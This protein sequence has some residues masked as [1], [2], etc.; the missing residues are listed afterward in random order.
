MLSKPYFERIPDQSLI[1]D[2]IGAKYDRLSATR[3]KK[4]AFV[5]TYTGR[6]ISVVLGKIAGKNVKA[7]WFDPRTG[8]SQPIDTYPNQGTKEFNP[9]GEPKNGNDWVLVL[10][11]F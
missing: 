3:G 9:P 2:E 10:E 5:Y 4:Y 7:S 11:S 8:Q 6:N 1:A